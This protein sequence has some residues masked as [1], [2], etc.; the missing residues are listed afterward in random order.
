MQPK[1]GKWKLI[2]DWQLWLGTIHRFSFQ[3]RPSTNWDGY[4]LLALSNLLVWTILDNW[5]APYLLAVRM[6]FLA[7]AGGTWQAIHCYPW[8]VIISRIGT[9]D[10][11][12]TEVQMWHGFLMSSVWLQPHSQTTRQ[13]W[14]MTRHLPI[15]IPTC[16]L[17]I[18]DLWRLALLVR[19]YD[20]SV[21]PAERTRLPLLGMA[22]SF[23]PTNDKVQRYLFAQSSLVSSGLAGN[24]FE[25]VTN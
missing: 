17:A 4:H 6:V 15:R 8:G 5:S 11:S 9:E 25:G 16:Y 1:R 22:T 13:R 18:G 19:R 2:V 24:L 14:E 21:F 23:P 10:A 20:K 7:K 12:R 3:R